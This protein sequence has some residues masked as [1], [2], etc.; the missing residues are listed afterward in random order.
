MAGEVELAMYRELGSVEQLTEALEAM[1][2][3]GSAEA[4]LRARGDTLVDA[5]NRLREADESAGSGD[6]MCVCGYIRKHHF[7]RSGERGFVVYG[8][9]VE[10]DG[11]VAGTTIYCAFRAANVQPGHSYA[12]LTKKASHKDA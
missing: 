7:D 3:W 6:L 10:D 1:R 12:H 9:K 11:N 2:A 4:L 5:I 8:Q